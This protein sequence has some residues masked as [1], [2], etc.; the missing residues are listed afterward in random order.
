MS[1]PMTSTQNNPQ[2]SRFP[3]LNVGRVGV[4]LVLLLILSAVFSL[5]IVETGQVAVITRSGSDQMRVISAPGV[6]VRLPF[7]ER[8]WL[9]DTRLQTSEQSAPQSYTSAGGQTLE[10]AG[11][12]AWRVKD[13]VQFNQATQTGKNPVDERVLK[14]L[15]ETLA[16]WLLTRPSSV[17]LQGPDADV[18]AQWLADLNPRL[19][20]L[21]LEADSV[22]LHQVGLDK[23]ATEA[24]YARM[25]AARTRTSRQLVEALQR[26]E[27]QSLDLQRR[28]QM[29]VLDDAYRAAQQ[30]RQTADNQLLAAYARQSGGANGFAEALRNPQPA[31][32]SSTTVAAPPPE[33]SAP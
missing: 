23:T 10:L 7:V 25:S 16:A 28:Q 21:G 2:N 8:A 32:V 3:Q 6:T 26:D 22:G 5:T 15:S 14:A 9:I 27:Q 31:A 13:A 12:V 29:Q 19:V 20:P 30:T 33:K 18:A 1:E 4:G 11:W 17:L 24:I